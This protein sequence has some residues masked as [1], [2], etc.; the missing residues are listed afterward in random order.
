MHYYP[1]NIGDYVKNT[2]HLSPEEDLCYRRL[3]DLYYDGESPIP[4]DVERVAKRIRV[5]PETVTCV[6]GE[7][8]SLT[9]DGYRNKRAD[10]EILAYRGF[11]ERQR[12][13]A[14]GGGKSKTTHGKATAK[15]RHSHG[16]ATAK[17]RLSHGIAKQETTTNKQETTTNKQEPGNTTAPPRTSPV[18]RPPD[19]DEAVWNDFLLLRR[20]KRAPFTNV[21]LKGIEREARKAGMSLEDAMRECIARG[22]QGFKAAWMYEVGSGG[23][24][25]QEALEARNRAVGN[26]WLAKFQGEEHEAD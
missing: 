2:T 18:V 16:I 21:A 15:P 25:K 24:N 23:V 5:D 10:K 8:F 22:W 9:D 6:L 1:F 7:F 11:I 3:L 4:N 19:V 20:A 14:L 12:A 17:P 13:N 26:A